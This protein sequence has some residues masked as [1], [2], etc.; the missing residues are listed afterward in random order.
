MSKADHTKP[1]IVFQKQSYKG[2]E[3]QEK[4]LFSCVKRICQLS[5]PN[6]IVFK[7]SSKLKYCICTLAYIQVTE[8]MHRE[9]IYK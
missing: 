2:S 9:I 6:C 3:R 7:M 8:R 1:E 5:Q 4:Y